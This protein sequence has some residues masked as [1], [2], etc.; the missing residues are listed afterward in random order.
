MWPYRRS[1]RQVPL[2]PDSRKATQRTRY[3]LDHLP[4]AWK[5]LFSTFSCE[6]AVNHFSHLWCIWTYFYLTIIFKIY[7]Y[8]IKNS[9]VNS[10][11]SFSC[12][13]LERL[14][15]VFFLP[16]LLLIMSYL[17]LF[18]DRCC[19][20]FFLAARWQGLVP[21]SIQLPDSAYSA[22]FPGEEIISRRDYLCCGGPSDS[23]T[24][25][26]PTDCLVRANRV[27]LCLVASSNTGHTSN[28]FSFW[29][30]FFKIP[31]CA[32]FFSAFK[33]N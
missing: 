17:W 24:T 25:W 11:V 21:P 12:L 31:L 28:S 26:Q 4:S 30:Y 9:T 8:Y 22:Q 33:K 13:V 18:S 7:F 16:P 10:M 14:C 15:S 27:L 5:S 2:T 3:H 32:H 23:N 20:L 19:F 1:V 6:S 29:W